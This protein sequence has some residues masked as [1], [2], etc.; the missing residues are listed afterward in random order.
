VNKKLLEQIKGA[1]GDAIVSG[2]LLVQ[3]EPCS[4]ARELQGR[5]RGFA[6]QEGWLCLTDRVLHF[7]D[8]A[9]LEALLPE[10]A[11]VLSGEL[12]RGEESLHIRQAETGWNVTRLSAGKGEKCLMFRES[13]LSTEARENI[14]LDYEVYW[15]LQADGLGGR[16]YLPCGFRFTGFA[17]GGN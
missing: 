17:E 4:S 11:V 13:Y 6:P 15:K 8:A 10:G 1:T 16:A 2:S 14:N 9:A 7:R 5:V 12:A 3:C